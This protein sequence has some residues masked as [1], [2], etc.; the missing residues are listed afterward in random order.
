MVWGVRSVRLIK[1]G[2]I[3]RV[4]FRFL[5]LVAQVYR[6]LYGTQLGFLVLFRYQKQGGIELWIFQKN[7]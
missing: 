4:D 5:P 1:I 7:Y 2:G 6:R 3:L